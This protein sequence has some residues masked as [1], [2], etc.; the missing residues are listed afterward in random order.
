MELLILWALGAAGIAWWASSRGRDAFGFAALALFLSPILAGI[1]LLMV[2]DL[3]KEAEEAEA[4]EAERI[5]REKA[6]RDEHERQ[7]ESIKVLAK[8]PTAT[9]PHGSVADELT[10]LAQLRDSGVL[11]DDEFAAQKAALLAP[12]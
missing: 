6:Q 5:E 3:K 8:A 2:K 1:I 7:L 12:K 9:A 4:K 11:T 10:K